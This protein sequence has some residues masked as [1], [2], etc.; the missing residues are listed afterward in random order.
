MRVLE[1]D[2]RE[3]LGGGGEHPAPAGEGSGDSKV[4]AEE[5]EHTKMATEEHVE[6]AAGNREHTEE[7]RK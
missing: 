3:M 6:P 7:R 1:E 5:C 4:D 2:E